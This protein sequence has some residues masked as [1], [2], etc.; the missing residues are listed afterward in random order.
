MILFDGPIR[1]VDSIGSTRFSDTIARRGP[2]WWWPEDRS[3]F[4]ANEIDHPWSYVGGSTD[5]VESLASRHDVEA[6]VIDHSDLW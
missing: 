6:V 5:L 1:R 3:W 2:Q 4:F